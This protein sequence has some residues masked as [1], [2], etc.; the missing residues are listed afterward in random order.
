MK[1]LRKLSKKHFPAFLF[2]RKADSTTAFGPDISIWLQPDITILLRHARLMLL[3]AQPRAV[4]MAYWASD[5][6]CRTAVLTFLAHPEGSGTLGRDWS[7]N[8]RPP[9]PR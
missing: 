9:K 6:T 8:G 3:A 5:M 4:T 7:D 2:L 1:F